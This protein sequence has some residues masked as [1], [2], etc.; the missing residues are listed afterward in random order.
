MVISCFTSVF[1][2]LPSK[3]NQTFCFIVFKLISDASNR[4]REIYLIYA[5]VSI[6]RNK[7][8]MLVYL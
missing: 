2:Q 4:Q 3:I 5:E 6:A 1:Q 8:N 7:R